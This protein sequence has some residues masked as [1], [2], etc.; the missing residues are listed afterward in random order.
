MDQ[1]VAKP[2]PP[3]VDLGDVRFDASFVTEL[4]AIRCPP[5]CRGK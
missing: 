1:I 5:T 3:L 4:P 2:V